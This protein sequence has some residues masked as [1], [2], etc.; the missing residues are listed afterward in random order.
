MISMLFSYY[1]ASN[2][3]DPIQQYIDDT[4]GFMIDLT[5]TTNIGIE[6]DQQDVVFLNGSTSTFL[7]KRNI[8]QFSTK[9]GT[10][11]TLLNL[12]TYL[13]PGH[14]INQQ[15]QMYTP[16]FSRNLDSTTGIK[17]IKTQSHR[18]YSK[19]KLNIIFIKH[20]ARIQLWSY[21][22]SLLCYGSNRRILLFPQDCVR[23][24]C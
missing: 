15:Y 4:N 5:S 18:S 2:P 8:S 14:T 9:I 10:S 1:D 24:N 6:L 17:S 3:A 12:I 20:K 22:Q 23:R 19:Y 16:V 7:K 21:L 11:K 13:G